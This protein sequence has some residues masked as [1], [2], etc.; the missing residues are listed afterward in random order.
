M[1]IN[2]RFAFSMNTP[3][4]EQKGTISFIPEGESIKGIFKSILGTNEYTG[5]K[6]DGDDFVFSFTADTQMGKQTMEVKGT[7]EDDKLTGVI[8]TPLG[9]FAFKGTREA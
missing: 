3:M 1:A 5:G 2:G 9:A 8:K 4:G 7:V 6:V